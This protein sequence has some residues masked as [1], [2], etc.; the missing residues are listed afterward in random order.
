M[1]EQQS[2]NLLFDTEESTT[3]PLS[4]LPSRY[5]QDF[6]RVYGSLVTTSA[7]LFD[8]SLIFGQPITD[9]TNN[10]Y[11]EQKVAVTM[12]WHAAKAFAGLLTRTIQNYE[13]QTGEIKLSSPSTQS[14]QPVSE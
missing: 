11:V 7:N 5:A 12:S 14:E 13:R 6:R 2:E 3:P 4:A 1:A 8:L 10:P 9:D